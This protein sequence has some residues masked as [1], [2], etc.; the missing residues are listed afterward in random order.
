MDMR[1]PATVG[2]KLETRQN[3]RQQITVLWLVVHKKHDD[4]NH[5]E[6]PEQSHCAH[7]AI[8]DHPATI[9]LRDGRPR[10]RADAAARAMTRGRL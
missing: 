3:W 2:P 1:S 10:R 4:A 6:L 7:C 8:A 9:G 5:H